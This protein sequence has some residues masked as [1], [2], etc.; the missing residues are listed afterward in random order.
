MGPNVLSSPAPGIR[1]KTNVTGANAQQAVGGLQCP[2]ARLEVVSRL[3]FGA[4][5]G[6]GGGGGVKHGVVGCSMSE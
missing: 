5:S 6:L 3:Q 2:S 1:V 4:L